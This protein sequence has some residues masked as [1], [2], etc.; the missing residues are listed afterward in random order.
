MAS[1][2]LMIMKIVKKQKTTALD[3][4][5][6]VAGIALPLS[7]IPQA[8]SIYSSKD[9]TGVSLLT[10]GFYLFSSTM[11]AI[12]GIIHKEKLLIFTY[13]PF[14]VIELIIVIGLLLYR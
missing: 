3:K 9:A 12:F 14:V 13:I 7:T 2:M 10:W 1:A 4:L 11:F 8:I 6:F 5:T